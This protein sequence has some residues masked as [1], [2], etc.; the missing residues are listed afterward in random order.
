VTLEPPPEHPV[1]DTAAY[2]RALGAFATGVCVVTADSEAGPLGITINS[3]TSVS[4]TPRLVLWC[5]DERSDR[6]PVFAAAETFAIH[7]LPSTDKPLAS[8]FAKGVSVLEPHEFVRPANGP[9]CLPEA[10]VRLECETHD[11]IQMGDHLIVIGRVTRFDDMGGEAL[12]YFRGRYG[13]ASEP[14]A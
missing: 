13:V 2:R 6:W 3:F 11:R 12:T 4:L 7:M 5:L 8:R 10:V 1:A 9:P 14:Q